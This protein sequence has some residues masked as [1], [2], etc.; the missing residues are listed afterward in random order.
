[1]CPA[2][3]QRVGVFQMWMQLLKTQPSHKELTQANSTHL[4]L[5][6]HRLIVHKIATISTNILGI[7]IRITWHNP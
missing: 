7:A 3:M 4:A 6:S 1:M 2:S 5:S